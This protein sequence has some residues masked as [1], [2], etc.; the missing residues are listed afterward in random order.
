MQVLKPPNQ[1]QKGMGT[2]AVLAQRD[3]TSADR[4]RTRPTLVAYECESQDSRGCRRSLLFDKARIGAPKLAVSVL[5]VPSTLFGS[6]KR[7]LG[8]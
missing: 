2:V 6:R 7:T 4:P 1:M 8:K 3:A 5:A